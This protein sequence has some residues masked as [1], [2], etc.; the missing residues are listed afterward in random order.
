M[1]NPTKEKRTLIYD[2]EGLKLLAQRL[3]DIRA[4]K[5]LSQDGLADEAGLPHSQ[6]ARIETCKTNPT[7]STLFKIARALNIKPSELFDFELTPSKK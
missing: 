1:K 7:A 2:E 6:I 4:D 3:K 5:D